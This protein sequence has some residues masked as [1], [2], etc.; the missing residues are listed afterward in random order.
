MANGFSS[1]EI[2]QIFIIVTEKL[3]VD[4]YIPN[5]KSNLILANSSA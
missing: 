3:G 1:G 5:P 4:T 2:C